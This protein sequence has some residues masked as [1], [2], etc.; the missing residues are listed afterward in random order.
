MDTQKLQAF[1]TAVGTDIKNLNNEVK[2]KVTLA[3]VKQEITNATNGAVTLQSV[4]DQ[5]NTA[6]AEL[7]EEIMGPDVPEQLNTM[8]EIADKLA[9]SGQDTNGAVVQAVASAKSELNGRIDAIANADLV[10]TYNQAK[11]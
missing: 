4:T 9:Q 5:I 6:K 3:E 11:A 2:T 1:A 7:K 10:A 8:K